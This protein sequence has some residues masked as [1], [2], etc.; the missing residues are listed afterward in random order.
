MSLKNN[1]KPVLSVNE[2]QISRCK[3]DYSK[4]LYPVKL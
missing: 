4:K 1:G 2:T 3:G